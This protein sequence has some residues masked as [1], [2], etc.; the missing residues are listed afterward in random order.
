MARTITASEHNVLIA[1][2]EEVRRVD[3]IRCSLDMRESA[4]HLVEFML[5]RDLMQAITALS[6][7]ETTVALRMWNRLKKH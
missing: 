6:Q 5:R 4:N 7:A 1:L 2:H 3:V